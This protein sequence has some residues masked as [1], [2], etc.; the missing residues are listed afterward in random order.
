M[1]SLLPLSLLLF[2]STSLAAQDANW[3]AWRGASGNGV[4]PAANPPLT[5]SETENIAWKV[6]LPGHGKSTP[7]VHG[8]RIFI[9]AAMPTEGSTE[10]QR[11]ELP[12]FENQLTRAPEE[13]MSFLV[14]A[15]D[16]RSG[17]LL[18]ETQ[19]AHRLQ[20]SGVHETNGYAS[21]SPVCDGERLYASF[22]SNGVYALDV[23]QGHV[24]WSYELGPQR[25]RKGWGEAGSPALA[26]ELLLVVADQEDDSWIHALELKSGKLR[27]K[28]ER[29][30][31]STWTVPLVL[32]VDGQLQAV[33][34]GTQAVRAY[35]V[36]TGEVLW[37]CPGQTTNAIPS[38]VSDGNLVVCTS[39]YGDSVCMAL[40]LRQ[41][42][43]KDP[44]KP[45]IAWQQHEGTPYVPSPLL[46]DGRLYLL[47]KNSGRLSCIELASGKRLID[48]ER[49]DLGN[50]YA[51]PIL[52][53]GRIYV[54]DRDGQ[55]AV[56]QHRERLEVL[57]VNQ[58][59]EPI[60]AS[61]VALGEV[62]YLR[63]ESSLYAIGKP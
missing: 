3:P 7:V 43:P 1:K 34:N 13:W 10:A 52:A 4:A 50:V 42:D 29:D 45:R 39:G 32:E 58:L 12:V 16:R 36:N 57:A 18:W 28:R 5:W 63:S 44:S 20:P 25:T 33:V 41:R 19:V 24:Q 9:L 26:G 37:S 62:L 6:G 2:W 11:S 17:E 15:L 35:D 27:W 61:P 56:L 40:D 31:P 54:V 55:T 8:E 59:E 30:E 14:L 23:E 60:D 47:N 38:P 21:F 22:G 48:R 46:S 53:A 49:L 51:S